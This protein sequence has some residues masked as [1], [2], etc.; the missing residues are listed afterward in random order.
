MRLWVVMH[1]LPLLRAESLA[2]GYEAFRKVRLKLI[3]A[4]LDG[5]ADSSFRYALVEQ[6]PILGACRWTQALLVGEAMLKSMGLQDVQQD[7]EEEEEAPP[8][9]AAAGP[10]RAAPKAKRVTTNQLATDGAAPYGDAS[11]YGAVAGLGHWGLASRHWRKRS[12]PPKQHTSRGQSQLTASLLCPRRTSQSQEILHKLLW[13]AAEDREAQGSGRSPEMQRCRITSSRIKWVSRALAQQGGALTL[14]VNHLINQA[15]DSSADFGTGAA[16]SSS[17]S[18]KGTARRDRLQAELAEHSGAFML[19]VGQQGFRR[20]FP[21]SAA[22][23]VLD[24]LRTSPPATE[25]TGSSEIWDC[26]HGW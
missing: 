7:Q 19:A 26:W 15:A 11:P 23:R 25:V 4:P 2:A 9:A 20:M 5:T 17:L 1:L 22:P 18:S 12:P 8:P 6:K 10:Q 21:A 13:P 16:G 24:D 3:A 14:L